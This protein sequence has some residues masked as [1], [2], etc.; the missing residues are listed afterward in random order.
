MKK[1]TRAL[2]LLTAV[3]LSFG[4]AITITP[5]A[6]AVEAQEQTMADLY[7]P[8][9]E[10][11]E[12]RTDDYATFDVSGDFPRETKFELKETHWPGLT[13]DEGPL[14]SY[15]WLYG[16]VQVLQSGLSYYG[17]EGFTTKVPVTVTYPDGSIEYITATAKLVPTDAAQSSI[18]YANTPIVPGQTELIAP[19]ITS[20]KAVR[21]TLVQSEEIDQLQQLGWKIEPNATTG[22]LAVTA[23][24]AEG[25]W[26]TIPI[27]VFYADGSSKIT[28]IGIQSRY[29]VIEPEPELVP[30]TG[31]SFSS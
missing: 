13:Y 17:E 10:F 8:Y 14:S 15:V 12:S 26:L 4:S 1:T 25:E 28:S 19:Y 29:P 31:S 9:Y 18:S 7:Q 5:V 24:E 16:R 11:F 22:E 21:Y 30:A 27:Q 23:P 2:T 3:S 6:T 20:E